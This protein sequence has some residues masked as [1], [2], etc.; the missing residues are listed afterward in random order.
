MYIA[1]LQPHTLAAFRPW[2]NF[3]G[4]GR[5]RL[6][7]CKDI[8]KSDT[9]ENQRQN[10]INFFKFPHFFTADHNNRHRLS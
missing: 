7:L 2:G 1:P 8:K 6:S 3:E 5:V 9:V 4:A 10:I